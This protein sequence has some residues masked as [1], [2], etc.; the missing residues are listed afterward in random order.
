M[1]LTFH[2]I[3]WWSFDEIVWKDIGDANAVTTLCNR[4]VRCF[5]V[6]CS[7]KFRN[8]GHPCGIA[9]VPA[10]CGRSPNFMLTSV[11]PL[12]Y[13]DTITHYPYS[14]ESCAIAHHCPHFLFRLPHSYIPFPCSLYV[15]P[16]WFCGAQ[17]NFVPV[18][19]SHIQSGILHPLP[20]WRG[21]QYP[22]LEVDVREA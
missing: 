16:S 11:A 3:L 18:I 8:W 20:R 5:S 12:Y 21:Y 22:V 6:V 13:Y 4:P 15:E 17:E 7:I 10:V 2:D 1:C 9:I 14:L 19:Q